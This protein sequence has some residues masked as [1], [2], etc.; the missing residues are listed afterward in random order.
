MIHELTDRPATRRIAIAS[1]A[2]LLFAGIVALTTHNGKNGGV[3]DARLTTKGRAIVTAV[4][5]QRRTVTG[6]VAMHSGETVEAVEGAMTIELPNGSTVEGRPSFKTS[7]PTRVKIAQPVE[8]L[9]G[10]LLVVA[11]NGADVDSGGNR[12]HLDDGIDGPSAARVS[13]SLAVG[14]AVFRGH[15]SFDSAG[16]TRAIPAL[17]TLEVSALG[18][19][20]S[21]PSVLKI[22][23]ANTDPWERRF[24][25]EAIDLGHTLD[26][27]ASTYT[28]TIGRG[29][30]TTVGS[31]KE[32]FPSLKEEADFTNSLL[33]ATPHDAGETFVGAAIGSLSRRGAF[34][35]RWRE[36]FAFRDAGANW[37]FVAL[38]QG[39]ATD[40]L[41]SALGT[42]LNATQFPFAVA[43]RTPPTAATTPSTTGGGPATTPTTTSGGGPTT[44]PPP[45]TSPSTTLVPPT[46]SPLVDGIVKNVNDL[47]GG[48]LGGRPPGG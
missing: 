48:L 31:F 44:S 4:N 12:V 30:G 40:P 11:T 20:P 16:Q 45:T 2:L 46:G 29:N 27:Y 37:G 43:A 9:A 1:V 25:G 19:P 6:T 41:L 28:R 3:G 10:D 26:G 14:A 47:L 15:A 39:V 36:A 33:S 5:G 7:D 8:L 35:D 22:D 24:L 18:R 42:A 32:A 17:R 38:D 21:S 13:R 34:A 23:D